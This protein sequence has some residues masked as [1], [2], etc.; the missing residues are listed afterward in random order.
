M[1]AGQAPALV[2][3]HR[4]SVG[5]HV[6]YDTCRDMPE[7]QINNEATTLPHH[8][9]FYRVPLVCEAASHLGCGTL[10]K[11][12]LLAIEDETA[13]REAWLNRKGTMLAVVWPDP[14]AHR[15]GGSLVLGILRQHGLTG[16]ELGE[17]ERL[18]A[19]KRFASGLDWYRPTWLD[20]LSDEEARVIAARIIAR[21]RGKMP[22]TLD[23]ANQLETAISAA[24]ARVLPDVST[25]STSGR[26]HEIASAILDAGRA[27]LGDLDF[28]IFSEA[29]ALGHRALP[30]EV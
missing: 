14:L 4:D 26:R 12:V 13:V 16:S 5:R 6:A 17:S 29:V 20:P 18:D 15:T 28:V 19:L 25:T 2:S 21:L 10:A 7:P 1:R 30:D 24:C 11:P 9:T 3:D 22:M 27:M 23:Q 8:V